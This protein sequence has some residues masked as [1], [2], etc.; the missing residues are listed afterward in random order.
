MVLGDNIFFGHGL[1]E[2]LV[3]AATRANRAR[4]YL[5]TTFETRND[6]V[7]LPSTIMRDLLVS[8]EKPTNPR[9]QIGRSLGYISLTTRLFAT[10][11]KSSH[12]R[13]GNWK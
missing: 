4:Q 8:E 3:K 1:P 11:L 10:P 12:R 6:M 5:H 13:V 2:L 9:V 7:W